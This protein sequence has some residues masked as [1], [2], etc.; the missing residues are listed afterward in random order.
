MPSRSCQNA[1]YIKPWTKQKQK[2]EKLT[3]APHLPTA[4]TCNQ[5]NRRVWGGDIFKPLKGW[6]SVGKKDFQLTSSIPYLQTGVMRNFLVQGAPWGCQLQV[7]HGADKT[8]HL[9]TLCFGCHTQKPHHQLVSILI[10]IFSIFTVIQVLYINDALYF[11][12]YSSVA[13]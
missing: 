2:T 7:L 4:C 5:Y 9:L 6:G 12:F 3:L 8:I 11:F 13:S 10:I 1:H